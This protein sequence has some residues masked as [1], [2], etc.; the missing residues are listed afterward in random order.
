MIHIRQFALLACPFKIETPEIRR[1]FAGVQ[2]VLVIVE[3]RVFLCD[4]SN[5]TSDPFSDILKLAKVQ[6]MVSGG[7]TAGG[8]W[9][10][11]FPAPDQIKFFALLKGRCWLTIGEHEEPLRVE[12]GDVVLLTAK[13]PYILSSDFETEPLD[14]PSLFHGNTNKTAKVG[15]SEDCIEIGSR[16]RLDEANGEILEHILPAMIH[17]H[18]ASPE[19]SSLKVLLDQIMREREAGLPGK[20]LVLTHLSELLFVQI[21]RVYMQSDAALSPSWLRA[22]NDK[23]L[24][25]ILRLMHADP[26]RNWQLDELAA[27]AAMSRTAFAVHFKSVA[28]IP[29]RAYLTELRM[30]IAKR[31]LRTEDT[32][33]SALAGFLGYTSESAFSTAFKRFSGISPLHYRNSVS[34]SGNTCDPPTLA[35]NAGLPSSAWEALM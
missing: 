16:V 25:P 34:G 27:K 19:A 18:A 11:R 21:L 8:A 7:F 2:T 30:R 10:L 4:S 31:V 22:V 28:G 13:K 26:A 24:A 23:R 29:P 5:M 15:D 6:P 1:C 12:E 32:P 33:I 20:D 3:R 35:E 14:G 17:V 9:A